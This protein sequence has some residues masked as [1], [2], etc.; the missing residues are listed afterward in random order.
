MNPAILSRLLLAIPLIA[1]S[2]ARGGDP[3][4]APPNHISFSRDV[5]PILT[6]SGCNSSK[7]HGA[8]E[9]LG[10][11]RLSPLGSDPAADYRALAKDDGGRRITTMKPDRS[12]LLR[13]LIDPSSTLKLTT[14]SNTYQVLHRWIQQGAKPAAAGDP[15][16]VELRVT[17]RV[18]RLSPTETAQLTVQA[19]WSDGATRDVTQLA[20]YESVDKAYATVDAA[21]KVKASASG[22]TSIQIQFLRGSAAVRVVVPFRPQTSQFPWTPESFIDSHAANAWRDMSLAPVG[23]C[24]DATYL[25]RLFL[26]V[27]GVPP[28]LL[29]RREFLADTAPDKRARLVDT[30][31][32]RPELAEHWAEHWR[33]WLLEDRRARYG[34]RWLLAQR[35]LKHNADRERLLDWL[36]EAHQNQLPLDRIAKSLITASGDTADNGAAAFYV[37]HA[38]PADAVRAVGRVFLGA[39]L[40]CARCHQ[41]PHA[42]WGAADFTSLQECFAGLRVTDRKTSSLVEWAA[43]NEPFEFRFSVDGQRA[44]A[45]NFEGDR[46]A[47]LA[48]WVAGEGSLAMA[49]NLVNRYWIELFAR[50]LVEPPDDL[51]PANLGAQPELLD[52]LAVDL[53]EHDFDARHL[54]RRIC[55]SRLYQL[56]SAPRPEW[57]EDR[58]FPARY[59]ARR[60]RGAALAKLLQHVAQVEFPASLVDV[61]DPK[62]PPFREDDVK[63]SRNEYR[64]FTPPSALYLINSKELIDAIHKDPR[65]LVQR[66]IASDKPLDEAIEDSFHTVLGRDSTAKERESIAAFIKDSS[67][68]ESIE[69]I[70]WALINS[71]ELIT[72]R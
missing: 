3:I 28:T 46:R 6:K 11:L 13:R 42:H 21:G 60:L 39:N 71:N 59:P 1:C 7:C 15:E 47:A 17:P 63:C 55:T 62:L 53:I 45:V 38:S 66:L 27:L 26:E 41:H 40:R 10:R 25:R 65:G 35:K 69:T 37:A 51:R 24:D 2:S 19:S 18:L 5:T 4:S 30:V 44:A 32:A 36:R 22:R 8:V 20:G 14:D 49:R 52:A 34:D 16:L 23:L 12:L 43:E 68:S 67:R 50:G 56:S 72:V 9:G 48:E 61:G 29:E 57:D 33:T 31:L 54:L 58:A 64:S 70:F